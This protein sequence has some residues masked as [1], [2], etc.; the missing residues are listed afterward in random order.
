MFNFNDIKTG[1]KDSEV[2]LDDYFLKI[3]TKQKYKDYHVDFNLDKYQEKAIKTMFESKKSLDKRV[4][5]AFK[6]DPFCLEAFFVFFMSN[7]DVFVNYRFE[8]YF[9]QAD[10]YADFDNYEK[11]CFINIMNFYVDFLLDIRNISRAIKVQR[12]IMRLTNDTTPLAINRLS[13][14]Y[15]TKEDADEFYRLYLHNEFDT[16]DYLLLIIALLKNDDE[17]RAKQV[18]NDMVNNIEYAKYLDHLW[19]LNLDDP[20]QKEFYDVVDDCFQDIMAIPDFFTWVNLNKE[21]K[22]E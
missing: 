22:K 10:N 16:Y 17:I 2:T 5:A 4:D 1:L 20:K 14:M 15:A 11:Y 6:L 21:N 8:S 9:D 19:D 3:F 7:E 12:L 13:F 18:L